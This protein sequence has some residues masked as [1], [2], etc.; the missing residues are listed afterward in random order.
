MSGPHGRRGR[1]D[2]RPRG[3]T[4]ADADGGR[5]DSRSPGD[6]EDGGR[7]GDRGLS[8]VVGKALEL[9]VVVLFVA[10]VS[11]TLY[12]DVVPGY[13]TA[14]AEE[15]GERALVDAAERVERAVPERTARL[16]RRVAVP[17]PTTIRGDAYRVRAVSDA[18]ATRLVLDH[19][20]DVGGRVALALPPGTTV[21]GA[22]ES[23][24]E[25]WAV[26]ADDGANVSVRLANEE[27][28]PV[29][30]EEAGP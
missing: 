30:N 6:R 25:S 21:A 28:G 20:D 3:R 29:R 17:L 23:G 26:V 18:D 4:D 12:G 11:T 1:G 10:L 13:R 5:G 2:C 7:R 22:W 24:S 16:D 27:G 8:P 19:P 9:G 14:A 15:V